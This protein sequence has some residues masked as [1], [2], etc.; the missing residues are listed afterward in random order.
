M[1][2][3]AS[4]PREALLRLVAYFESIQASTV[5]QLRELYTLDAYFRDPFN[6]VRGVDAIVEIFAAM[7]GPL[8]E[9]RFQIRESLLEGES[10]FLTW[11]FTFRIRRWQPMQVRTIH[12]SSHL[13]FTDG[14]RV[15]YHRDYWDAAGELYAK[16]PV[17]G[18]VMRA[19]AKRMG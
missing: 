1:T 6:E 16:L 10:A 19:L 17:I 15:H 9:P 13:K 7:Y 14:G 11:D 2:Q 5:P 8:I 3:S 4:D 12:G 18:S